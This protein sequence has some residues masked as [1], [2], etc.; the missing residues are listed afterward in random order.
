MKELHSVQKQLLKLLIENADEPL[1]IRAL[2]AELGASSPSVVSHHLFQLERKG[3]LKRDPYNPRD[4]Q[5]LKNPSRKQVSYLNL[6]GLVHCGPQG[7]ILDGNPID[8]IPI[9]SRLIPF[10]PKEAFLVKAKNDSMEPKIQDGDLVIVR[11]TSRPEDG[12]VAVCINGGEA[13]IKQLR[14]IKGGYILCSYNGKYR[15]FIPAKDFRVVGEV[16]GVITSKVR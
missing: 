9:A 15:P 14:K 5:I 7:S 6:Y 4:Y 2:Q 10:D 1:T 3:Y 12:S 11:K 16:R 13:L 8:R